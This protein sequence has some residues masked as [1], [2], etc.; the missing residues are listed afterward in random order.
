L[1]LHDIM[2]HNNRKLFLLNFNY[3]YF[4]GLTKSEESERRK[5]KFS[6]D[7][8]YCFIFICKDDLGLILK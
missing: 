2:N 7:T 5:A 4:D 8:S 1:I 3:F 6:G